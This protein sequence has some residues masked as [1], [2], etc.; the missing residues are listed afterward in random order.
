ML[1]LLAGA[2]AL[3]L[4]PALPPRHAV[5]KRPV[6]LRAAIDPFAHPTFGDLAT[7]AYGPM[8][9]SDGFHPSPLFTG[10]LFYTVGMIFLT[11]WDTIVPQDDE[12]A[13]RVLRK[14][15]KLPAAWAGSH[16]YVDFEGSFR[17]TSVWV[18]G[19]HVNNGFDC[20]TDH[21][22]IAIQAEGARAEFRRVDLTSL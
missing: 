2:A 11:L 17:L 13:K 9:Q 15:F 16:V 12:N 10:L 6:A 8:A 19:E 14:A 20:T 4:A 5:S 7:G 18:N 3:Q 1:S 22:Q 21:G